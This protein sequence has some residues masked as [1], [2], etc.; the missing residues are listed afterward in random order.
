MTFLTLSIVLILSITWLPALYPFFKKY[1]TN[2]DN[3]IF[4]RGENFAC[5]VF[6]GAGLVHILADAAHTFYKVHID[7]PVPFVI[8]GVTILSLFSIE[9]L[10]MKHNGNIHTHD[11]HTPHLHHVSHAIPFISVIFLSIHSFFAGVALGLGQSIG[12]S[13]ILLMAII[14]HKWAEAFALSIELVKKLP[15]KNALVAF[16]IFSFMTP[17]GILSGRLIRHFDKHPALVGSILSIAAGTFI[18]MALGHD[19]HNNSLVRCQ[20]FPKNMVYILAGFCLMC[21]LAFFV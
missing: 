4:F 20:N 10:Y 3:L 5:G 1:Q 6:L 15:L 14:A 21:V 7:Y 9:H 17:I 19:L 2:Q 13:L 16:L 12:L 8:T 18:Y 11:D